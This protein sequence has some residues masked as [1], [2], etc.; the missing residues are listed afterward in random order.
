[1]ANLDL[2]STFANSSSGC[3]YFLMYLSSPVVSI[4]PEGSEHTR[5][6]SRSVLRA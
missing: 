1:M 6:C 5:F 4:S 3:L 2:K